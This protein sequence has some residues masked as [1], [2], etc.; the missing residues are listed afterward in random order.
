V[1]SCNSER[2]FGVPLMPVWRSS[3][4]FPCPQDLSSSSPATGP[5]PDPTTTIEGVRDFAQHNPDLSDAGR[6]VL[7]GASV[8]S[9]QHATRHS[10]EL[11]PPLSGPGIRIPFRVGV[12][13]F[14]H[15]RGGE[16][17]ARPASFIRKVVGGESP[18][19]CVP[20]VL[21]T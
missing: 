1:A 20:T 9:H 13:C 19:L 12:R 17:G 14:R 3:Q 8:T 4:P 7:V 16:E 6:S 10:H 2:G 11:D 18:D 15:V 5:A 21:L